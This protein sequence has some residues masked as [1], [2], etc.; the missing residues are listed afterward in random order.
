MLVAIQNQ[1]DEDLSLERMA[2]M[3][4]MSPYHFHR[5][6][7]LTIGETLKQYTQR[8]RLERAAWQL[9]LRAATVLE[10]ALDSGF[11]HH[12][13]FSRAF[14]QRFGLSPDRYRR[15]RVKGPSTV[16]QQS[17]MSLNRLHK[18]YQISKVRLQTLKPINLAFIRNL[19]PYAEVDAGLFDRLIEWSRQQGFSRDDDLLIGI[20]H[21]APSVTAPDKLRFDACIQV[22][23]RFSAVGEIGWRLLPSGLFAVT[24]YIGPY[25]KTMERAYVEIVEAILRLKEVKLSGLP[26]VEIYRTTAINPDYELDQTDICFPI[27][28]LGTDG[29]DRRLC[30]RRHDHQSRVAASPGPA[31]RSLGEGGWES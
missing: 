16:P 2:G 20:G 23:E 18:N 15:S 21:D 17:R 4:N 26:V 14:K 31:L 13:T 25:G 12:E 27:R 7:K 22:P 30:G 1:L 24:A 3:A 10:I 19:G 8:L 5:I 29:I 6:F 28:K 9:K 11:H